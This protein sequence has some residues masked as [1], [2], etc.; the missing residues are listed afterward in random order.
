MR[1]RESERHQWSVPPSC[2]ASE[3]PQARPAT[4]WTTERS[5]GVR[6]TGA[7]RRAAATPP[8]TGPNGPDC[9]GQNTLP[10]LFSHY[11]R[12][13]DNSVDSSGPVTRPN[14][15]DHPHQ[16]AQAEDPQRFRWSTHSYHSK[17]V[18]ETE[19]AG[20]G[21]ENSHHDQPE[22]ASERRASRRRRES[23]KR[24]PS[25][26]MPDPEARRA[27]RGWGQ[28]G[29]AR[30]PNS[31]PSTAPPIAPWSSILS[32]S[33]REV[34]MC[35]GLN[36]NAGRSFGLGVLLTPELRSVVLKTRGSSL[37]RAGIWTA[38]S[39]LGLCPW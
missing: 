20:E 17:D 7:Q 24:R 32:C 9:W 35:E 14:T 3:R 28:F 18:H 26:A 2:A 38:G 30:L 6:A 22:R 11:R 1:G 4:V 8:A 27:D 5:S 34:H 25:R 39:T 29:S 37:Y 16:N 36:M 21:D 31:T 19:G 33:I 13:D 15:H 23:R 12:A 10:K